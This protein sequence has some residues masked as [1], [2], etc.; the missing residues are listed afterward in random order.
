MQVLKQ[1]NVTSTPYVPT[2]MDPSFA[3]VFEVMRAMAETVQVFIN[4]PQS[5]I[6]D[7]RKGQREDAVIVIALSL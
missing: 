2:L 7:N 3:A 5:F 6:V 4:F 1:M